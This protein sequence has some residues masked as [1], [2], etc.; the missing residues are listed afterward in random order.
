M[1]A[2]QLLLPD[3]VKNIYLVPEKSKGSYFFDKNSDRSILDFF[4]FFSTLPLGYNHPI[5]SSS[6]FLNDLAVYGGFKFSTGRIRTE[7]YDRFV[8][9]F[10]NVLVENEETK[11]FLQ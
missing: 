6:E 3:W 10:H 2:Q 5:Y 4:S 7:F 1:T 9:E 11:L 8:E